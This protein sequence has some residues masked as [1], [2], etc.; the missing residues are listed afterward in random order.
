MDAKEYN[1][2]VETYAD[3]VYRFALKDLGDADEAND[4]VQE[5]FTRLWENKGKV[6]TATVKSYL[7]TMA[8]H[9]I[10]D[11][12]RRQQKWVQDEPRE[13][14]KTTNRQYSDLKEVLDEALE[15]LPAVQRSVVLLR[16]YEGYSYEEISEMTN[17]SLSQ[18]KVYIFRARK[19][20]KSYLVSIEHLV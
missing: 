6:R 10:I 15:Q 18:V 7:F 17:L 3:R 9:L 2:C 14:H 20:L 1:H 16:D 13:H 5:C 12:F 19:T 11:Q 8:Y 4:V